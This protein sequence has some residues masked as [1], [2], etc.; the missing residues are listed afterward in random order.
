MRSHEYQLN[1]GE[2]LRC[3]F[4]PLVPLLC[5]IVVVKAGILAGLLPKP[6]PILDVDRTILLHQASASRQPSGANVLLVGDSSCLMNV[7]APQLQEALG[8]NIRVLNLGTLSYL[9]PR[10]YGRFVR[11]Y[12]SANSSVRLVVLLMHP[13]ALR[14]GSREPYF[15]DLL[16][17]SERGEDLCEPGG[18]RILCATGINAVRGRILAR[19]L[20]T[21]LPGS[22]GT[23]YGFSWDLWNHLSQQNG[24]AYDPGIFRPTPRSSEYS[25]SEAIKIFSR[26]FHTNVPPGVKLAI[27]IT[28]VPAASAPVGYAEECERM[29]RQWGN[30]IQADLI[31][32][33]LPCSL[34][35]DA[36]ASSAHLKPEAIPGY[37][38]LLAEELKSELLP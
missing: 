23:A 29:A 27:G 33:R 2:V 25:L 19:L 34:E 24:S 22:Y 21:P 17:A 36:F 20:P 18:S 3:L 6:R 31:L 4:Y 10:E 30:L 5:F 38:K 1:S 12:V 15:S 26:S 7:S 32:R 9:D 35:N 28:P 13:E 37:T 11:N 16:R 8:G 14:L